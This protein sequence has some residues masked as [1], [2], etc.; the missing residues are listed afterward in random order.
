MSLKIKGQ[1][2]TWL[3]YHPHQG[4]WNSNICK[5]IRKVTFVPAISKKI[6]NRLIKFDT[7]M[8]KKRLEKKTN[9][10]N[11]SGYTTEKTINYFDIGTHEDANELRWTYDEVL[12]KLPNPYKILTFE[13]NPTSYQKAADHIKYIPNLKIINAALLYNIPESGTIRLFTARKGLGDSIY[14]KTASYVDVPARR[15]SD[16]IK[17]EKI[18]LEKGINIL[19]MNIEGAEYD[20][21]QDLID[22]DLVKYFDGFYGMWDDL[23]KI[24][25]E[26]DVEFIKMLNKNGIHPYPFNGRDIKIKPRMDLIKMSLEQS[27]GTP[28]QELTPEPAA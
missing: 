26:K 25:Y 12:S 15:L 8:L 3:I 23:S 21:I 13:A 7:A 2:I 28:I 27:I 18:D 10:I 11:S 20:V 19:R 16:I 9:N 4:Y 1:P 22:N 17:E 6:I 5:I 24:N 14:R